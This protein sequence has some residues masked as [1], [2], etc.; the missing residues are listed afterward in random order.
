M[1]RIILFIILIAL[2]YVA[3]RVAEKK[4]YSSIRE[5]EKNLIHVPAHNLKNPSETDRQVLKSELAVGQIVVSQD[6]FKRFLAILRG[7]VGGT[8][9]SYE[10]LVDRGRRDAVL[11]MK[12]SCSDADEFINLRIQTSVIGNNGTSK[13]GLGSIEVLAYSTAVYYEGR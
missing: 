3:G 8:M 2:G 5:R 12:E 6:Y 7:I 13:N 10:S 1:E 11:R 9:I 4:H